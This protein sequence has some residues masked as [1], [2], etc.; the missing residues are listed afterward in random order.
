VRSTACR[1]CRCGSD[2]AHSSFGSC[3]QRTDTRSFG[4]A[5]VADLQNDW[6]CRPLGGP[7]QRTA[8]GRRHLTTTIHTYEP[9]SIFDALPGRRCIAAQF[10]SCDGIC[11][12][13]HESSIILSVIRFCAVRR[14]QP[15][16]CWFNFFWEYA[17]VM[18]GDVVGLCA[19]SN[20][21]K[22]SRPTCP[23]VSIII[24]RPLRSDVQLRRRMVEYIHLYF[25]KTVA[26]I[27]EKN[28]TK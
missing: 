5:V 28:L 25:T 2:C 6:L 26:C 19:L 8:I 23:G 12:D 1:R 17:A 21:Y 20:F 14:T 22:A 11:W 18:W 15:V 9:C 7:D 13:P 3:I 27:K 16:P 10:Y 24:L 4:S